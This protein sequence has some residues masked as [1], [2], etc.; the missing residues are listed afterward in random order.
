MHAL[1]KLAIATVMPVIEV[2]AVASV[3]LQMLL[4]YGV[5]L[6]QYK[7][8]KVNIYKCERKKI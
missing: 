1:I 4:E 7:I 3:K 8:V 2:I 5:Y 6:E